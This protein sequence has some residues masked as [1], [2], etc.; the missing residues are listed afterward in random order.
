[1]NKKM[2]CGI[3]TTAVLIGTCSTA[4]FAETTLTKSLDFRNMKEDASG[5][6]WEWNARS[7]R[8]T[9]EDFQ[10]TVPYDKLEEKAAIYL[11]EESSIKV[12]GDNNYLEVNS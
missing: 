11:P 6:G 2:L 5:N 3:L 9:L 12:K 10:A 7:Q 1:M 4:A 8:L